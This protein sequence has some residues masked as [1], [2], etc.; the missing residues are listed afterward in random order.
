MSDFTKDGKQRSIS[1]SNNRYKEEVSD[2]LSLFS[3]EYYCQDPLVQS[4]DR[5]PVRDCTPWRGMAKQ[6]TEKEEL[7]A[8]N[9]V[10]TAAA[11]PKT[12]KK[13]L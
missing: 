9:K 10:P 11:A 3:L 1:D 2:F 7:P 13:K 4:P 8:V 12:S 6:T 5:T